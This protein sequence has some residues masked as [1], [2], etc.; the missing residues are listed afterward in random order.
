MGMGSGIKGGDSA[1]LDI[2][3]FI[4][5]KQRTM[6]RVLIEK[7]RYILDDFFKVEEAYLQFEKFNGEM[8]RT[9][10]RF[11][12]ER[13][14]SV[15]VLAFNLNTD[16]LILIS[17]FRYPT[18]K[19]GHGWTIE[20][21]AGIIDPSET[22]E[23]AARREVQEETGLTLSSLEHIT[24]FYPS[25]GGSSE[26][27]YLYYSEVSAESSRNNKPG[28]LINEGENII[29]LE[30]SLEEAL[31][32]IKAGEIMDAKTIIGIYWLESRLVKK[33]R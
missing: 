28:G 12:L 3:E 2:N 31:K 27:I 26:Q 15:S 16:K 5:K 25:P 22:P 7:K 23:E 20:A 11:S 19:N 21:I 30:I 14:D 8:S 18:Y 32:K 24:T 17:Q 10:R 33:N 6:K 13:G 9:V 1:I 29:S 4:S